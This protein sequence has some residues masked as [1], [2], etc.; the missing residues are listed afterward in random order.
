L[1]NGELSVESR[2]AATENKVVMLTRESES[3][4]RGSMTLDGSYPRLAKPHP[5]PNSDRCS[6]AGLRYAATTALL[7]NLLLN[8]SLAYSSSPKERR[9]FTFGSGGEAFEFGDG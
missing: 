7:L 3:P 5:G 8:I 2:E 9:I 1:G 6:A 4:L